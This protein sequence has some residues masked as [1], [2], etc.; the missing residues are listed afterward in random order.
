MKI[1]TDRLILRR[2]FEND[3]L[4][5]FEYLSDPEVVKFEPYRPMVLDEVWKELDLRIA[6]EEMVAVE[7]KSSGKLIGNVYLGKRGNSVL[8]IGFVFNKDYW[9]QGYAMESCAAMIHEAFS[10]GVDRI[11]AHCEPEN[12]NSW[13]LLERLGFTQTA[14]LEKNVF[15]W[16]D[17]HDQP[18]WKDTYIYSLEKLEYNK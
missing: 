11:I 3:L 13:N 1:E 5:L 6:S 2:F 14:H 4:D 10:S 7:L 16:K 12:Q 8:E 18:I 15:F 17:D 9:K